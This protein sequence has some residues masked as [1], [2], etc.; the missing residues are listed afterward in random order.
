MKLFKDIFNKY[1]S[2]RP[3]MGNF[4]D[5]KIKLL[6]AS[7]ECLNDIREEEKKVSD[8]EKWENELIADI[9]FV[10]SEYWYD[11][12]KYFEKIKKHPQNIELQNSIKEKTE[13][14]L[15]EYE[16]QKEL[17]LSRIEFL[18]AL[19]K[20]YENLLTE[21]EKLSPKSKEEYIKSIK[22][23]RKKLKEVRNDSEDFHKLYE[24]SEH[25]KGIKDEMKELEE[26][27]LIKKEVN[28][29]IKKITSEYFDKESESDGEFLKEEINRLKKD[30]E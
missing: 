26:D 10:P 30:M 21:L 22:K 8:I 6:K 9:Y 27:F 28:D 1:K 23:Y 7:Q 13:K 11:E 5:L 24:E 14:L 19:K 12:K 25:F 18:K 15:Q 2:D 4:D 16:I 3:D 29:Y 17:I 20:K